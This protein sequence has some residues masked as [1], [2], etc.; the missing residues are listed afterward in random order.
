V[1]IDDDYN[2]DDDLRDQRDEDSPINKNIGDLRSHI[3]DK[4]HLDVATHDRFML[5]SQLEPQ[6]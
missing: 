1:E 5:K 2:F 6:V 4:D 3:S